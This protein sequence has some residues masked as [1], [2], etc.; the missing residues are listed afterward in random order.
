MLLNPDSCL[1]T[2]KQKRG[3]DA[4][5]F[6][7]LKIYVVWSASILYQSHILDTVSI[8][9]QSRMIQLCKSQGSYSLLFPQH[10]VSEFSKLMSM[11][12][13]WKSF[14]R[15]SPSLAW[16]KWR[17]S[18]RRAWPTIQTLI[19]ISNA[20]HVAHSIGDKIRGDTKIIITSSTYAI[21]SFKTR[22]TPDSIS[23][24]QI[25]WVL[26]KLI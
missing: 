15:C 21:S 4:D 6:M 18:L 22:S 17:D 8:S 11:E 26:D 13:P 14:G 23:P 5:Y 7:R 2:C 12:H 3:G 9:L 16:A 20:H 10:T 1:L 19:S 24:A 25:I